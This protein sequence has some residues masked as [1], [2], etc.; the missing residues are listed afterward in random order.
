MEQQEKTKEQL[1][2]EALEKLQ[3]TAEILRDLGFDVIDRFINIDTLSRPTAEAGFP[4][5]NDGAQ[6]IR[7]SYSQRRGFRIWFTNGFENPDSPRRQEVEERLRAE[8]LL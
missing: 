7:V 8:G 5:V 6:G 1:L 3:R 4:V 2:Y